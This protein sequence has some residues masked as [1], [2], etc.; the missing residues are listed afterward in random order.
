MDKKTGFVAALALASTMP[1]TCA[2][3]SPQGFYFTAFGGQASYDVK[4]EDIDDLF[5]VAFE[6]EGGI[7]IDGESSLDD[8]DTSF[9]AVFGYRFNPYFA[10]EAA[11]IDLG[12]L[13]Y[14]GQADVFVPPFGVATFDGGVSIESQGPAVSALGIWP[15]ADAFDLYARFGLFFSDT[16]AGISIEDFS[17]SV[18]G[19]DED[20]FYGVGAAWNVGERWT[21]RLD[22][23]QF[24]DVG[25]EEDTGEGDVD[26]W[27]LGVL[28]RI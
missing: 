9:G 1:L 26:A 23:Q 15:V 19:S 16:E 8:S 18:S 12:S 13:E 11:Y 7:V 10:V 2:A 17:E 22:Y 20:V 21:L 3:E 5:I 28:F 25:T 14:R 27:S 24:K 6:E 4:K